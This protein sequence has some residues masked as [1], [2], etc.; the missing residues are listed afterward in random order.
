[1]ILRKVWKWGEV[2]SPHNT[3]LLFI[4]MEKIGIMIRKWDYTEKG[5]H[6]NPSKKNLKR[7]ILTLH[8]K[9]K[10]GDKVYTEYS[11]EKDNDGNRNHIHIILH[12]SD[13]ENLYQNLSRF[14]GDGKWKK[15]EMG[16][17]IFDECNGK[18][19]LIH[20]EPI[21]DEWKYRNY[22]NKKESTMTLI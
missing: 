14:I 19:G 15:R 12:Y 7:Q 9:L 11:I 1:V 17:D 8:R 5:N 4:P 2:D 21:E 16:L 10:K 18:Y 22:L 20:T 6:I 3:Y 13:K